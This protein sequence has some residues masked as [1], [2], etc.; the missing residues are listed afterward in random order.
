MYTGSLWVQCSGLRREARDVGAVQDHGKPW[1]GK[2][3]TIVK[4]QGS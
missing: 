4:K 2:A 3:N 1:C